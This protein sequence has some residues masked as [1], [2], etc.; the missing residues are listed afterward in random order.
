MLKQIS[1]TGTVDGEEVEHIYSYINFRPFIAP[2]NTFDVCAILPKG[3][4]CGCDGKTPSPVR[5]TFIKL[6]SAPVERQSIT[7]RFASCAISPMG[8]NCG[9]NGQA[10]IFSKPGCWNVAFSQGLAS[11]IDGNMQP[12]GSVPGEGC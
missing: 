7:G 2:A 9:C 10:A 4:N 6:R 3:E 1:V 5:L 12:V 11:V 8:K